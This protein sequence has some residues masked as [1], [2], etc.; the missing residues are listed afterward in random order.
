MNDSY[1]IKGVTLKGEGK[2]IYLR[3]IVLFLLCL[4]ISTGVPD[5]LS[6]L[7]LCCFSIFSGDVCLFFCRFGDVLLVVWFKS[8]PQVPHDLHPQSRTLNG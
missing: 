5:L 4:V 1:F 2:C 8:A 7:S 3:G 6:E